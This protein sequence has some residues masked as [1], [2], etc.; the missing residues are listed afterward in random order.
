MNS[1][2]KV[3]WNARHRSGQL[4]RAIIAVG[5]VGLMLTGC[6][7]PTSEVTATGSGQSTTG[8]PSAPA[9]P[10]SPSGGRTQSSSITPP[11]ASSISPTASPSRIFYSVEP[12]PSPTYPVTEPDA[13]AVGSRSYLIDGQVPAVA[14]KSR[15]RNVDGTVT[16][17]G[18]WNIP[19]AT[20]YC[21]AQGHTEGALEQCRIGVLFGDQKETHAFTAD[22][23]AGEV[24]THGLDDPQAGTYTR[25]GDNTWVNAST[26][27]IRD[28]TAEG[29][30]A[31]L[32]SN[33][34]LACSGEPSA[35]APDGEPKP[36]EA[37]QAL[38][39]TMG[40]YVCGHCGADATLTSRV[41]ESN[42]AVTITAVWDLQSARAECTSTYARSEAEIP[43]CLATAQA[44]LSRV[45][46]AAANCST[47]YLTTF[48]GATDNDIPPR[49]YRPIAANEWQQIDDG[50]IRD[51]S[52]AGGG[53]GMRQNFE[54]ACAGEVP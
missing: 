30:G 31:V 15:T 32:S 29:G 19:G 47:G 42:G 22:C 36:Y 52:V 16:I 1:K 26:G 4:P 34:E 11:S 2:P 33:F 24:T 50:A 3:R 46:R 10:N 21:A 54:L 14:L 48:G 49:T 28:S 27:A 8:S 7:G 35:S 20:E 37:S 17:R 9:E 45:Y 5:T 43:A 53:D 13:P 39:G 23:D 38:I 12:T 18:A 6:S 44:D 25:G 41:R 40:F 51:S